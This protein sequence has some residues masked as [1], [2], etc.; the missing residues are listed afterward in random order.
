VL[1]GYARVST[2]LQDTQAQEA[3]LIELGVPAD[4][5]YTDTGFSGK[6]MTRD[7]LTAALAAVRE[8]DTF[9]VSR[10]D[11]L[12][13]NVEGALL[14]MRELTE[15][16][17]VFQNGTTRYD[18]AD[19]LSKMVMTI[20]LAVAEAEGGWISLRTREAMARPAVRAKLTGRRPALSPDTDAAIT[21]YLEAGD[22]PAGQIATLF[23]TSRSGVY[24]A[25]ARHRARV[26]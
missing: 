16:G 26:S 25:A 7:G 10:L 18:P 6:S 8:G 11:R 3:A 5:V 9:V 23:R 20:L 15:R 24:R 13:R 4:R 22:K 19:P 1:V 14:I 12:A 2:V 17:V 21:A